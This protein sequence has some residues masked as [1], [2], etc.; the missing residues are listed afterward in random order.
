[1]KLTGLVIVNGPVLKLVSV[2]NN[3]TVMKFIRSFFQ[4]R[5]L[6]GLATLN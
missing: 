1:M 6:F 4:S 5:Y 3:S 2:K